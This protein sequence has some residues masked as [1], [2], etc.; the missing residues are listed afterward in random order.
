MSLKQRNDEEITTR[1]RSI[2]ISMYI[3]KNNSSRIKT[4][5]IKTLLGK[6]DRT[7]Y[8]RIEDSSVNNCHNCK[9]EFNFINRKHH[10]RN[11][12][13]IFCSKCSNY[14][15]EIPNF[16]NSVPNENNYWSLTTYMNYFNLNDS[17]ERTCE[18]CFIKIVELKHLLKTMEIFD[19]LSLDIMD[20]KKLS[21]VCKSWN[22]V[23]N[24]YFAFFRE[25]QYHLPDH[26]YSKKEINILINNKKY[27]SQH[28]KWITQL[29]LQI[30]YCLVQEV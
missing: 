28:S 9:T 15:I 18:K 19:L 27:L 8:T 11:C 5:P 25:I 1:H 6:D 3:D 10:C 20:Y 7:V 21:L 30:K 23:S 12:G 22:K 2:S 16:V 29:I 4:L 17:K 13:K 14:W 26:E 24:Y